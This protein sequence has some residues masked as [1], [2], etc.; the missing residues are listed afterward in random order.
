M[1]I[2]I[3]QATTSQFNPDLQSAEA[4]LE[5]LLVEGE[6][7]TRLT[8]FHRGTCTLVNIKR[9]YK[10]SYK[11]NWSVLEYVVIPQEYEEHTYKPD[12]DAE[13]D[14]LPTTKMVRAEIEEMIEVE[15]SRCVD[16]VIGE[17]LAEMMTAMIP[18][19]FNEHFHGRLETGSIMGNIVD[20]A[21]AK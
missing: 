10:K 16:E 5:H 17:R 2:K 18:L 19:V 9:R 4:D 15:V 12:P 6:P 3:Q 11:E 20:G 14:P 13:H 8:R 1:K 7:Q 21:L